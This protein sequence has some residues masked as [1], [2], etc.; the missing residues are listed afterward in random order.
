MKKL[1]ACV[2]VLAAVSF[3]S[4]GSKSAETTEEVVE[5]SVVEE[6]A[7]ASEEAVADTTAAEVAPVDSAAVEAVPAE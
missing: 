3:T 5:T 4:C 2:A 1:V 6:V 7:P